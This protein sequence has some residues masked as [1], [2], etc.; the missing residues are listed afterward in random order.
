MNIYAESNFVSELALMQAQFQSCQNILALCESGRASL[1]L[2]AFCLAEPY[3]TLVRRAKDRKA[4]SR[5][6]DIEFEQLSRTSLY[7]NQLDFFQQV[8][9]VLVQTNLDEEQRLQQALDRI[10][11]VCQVIPM[12]PEILKLAADYRHEPF[13]LSIQDSI[14]YAS[15][16]HH[17]TTTKTTG[18]KCFL[19]R[20]SRDFN[21]PDI[22]AALNN[23]QC[24]LLFNFDKG[25]HYIQSQIEGKTN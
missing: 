11:T 17:L 22:Q 10:L 16:I 24:K 13:E 12:V 14:V 19:T 9:Q 7:T 20:N 8:S 6:L 2:P 15:V 21:K 5:Q 25:D 23:H 3:D 18:Q 4:L 1:T